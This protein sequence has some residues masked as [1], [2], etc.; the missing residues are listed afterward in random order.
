MLFI[1]KIFVNNIYYIETTSYIIMNDY[2][3]VSPC[4][5]ITSTKTSSTL[6][7]PFQKSYK[8]LYN[9]KKS[10]FHSSKSTSDIHNI[11]R[12]MGYVQ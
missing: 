12:G 2:Y 5:G 8:T 9:T 10:S 3:Y 11:T 6:S 4:K 7:S 1:L